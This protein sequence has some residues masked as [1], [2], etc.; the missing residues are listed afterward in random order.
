L[1]RDSRARASPRQP[2]HLARTLPAQG[3]GS[4]DQR[5]TDSGRI[6]RSCPLRIQSADSIVAAGN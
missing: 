4:V 3:A 6:Q 2:A 1:A 5:R